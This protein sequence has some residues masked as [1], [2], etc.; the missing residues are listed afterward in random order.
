MRLSFA[1][2]ID[3]QACADRVHAWVIAHNASYAASVQAGQTTA[4]AKP[5]QDLDIDRKPLSLN[6]YINL[7]DRSFDALSSSEKAALVPFAVKP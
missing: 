6:W 3:A 2:Q 7:K 4:W 1:S 5:Y